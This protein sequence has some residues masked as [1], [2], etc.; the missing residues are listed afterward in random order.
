MKHLQLYEN[1]TD[2]E[3]EDLLG[4]LS[5]VGQVGKVK[6]YCFTEGSSP[7]Q[8]THPSW[9][10]PYFE[11]FAEVTLVDRGSDSANK[12][13]ALQKIR[14]GEFHQRLDTNMTEFRNVDPE[15]LKIMDKRNIQQVAS[16]VSTLDLLL[17]EVRTELVETIMKKWEEIH[18]QIWNSLGDQK[19]QDFYKTEWRSSPR[20]IRESIRYNLK[21]GIR[22]RKI[23]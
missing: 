12:D 10:T 1:Y 23:E 19:M 9:W 5:D 15:A 11:V 3:L 17:Q 13:F 2:K 6:V 18:E 20:R 7:Q 14:R 22:I 16:R 8:D 4:N 21:S